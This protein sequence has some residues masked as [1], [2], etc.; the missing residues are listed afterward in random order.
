VRTCEVRG[1]PEPGTPGGWPQ[2]D[3]SEWRL[4]FFPNPV[5]APAGIKQACLQYITLS[6]L[7]KVATLS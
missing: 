2:R 7:P 4:A 5:A 1:L 6:D 3:V